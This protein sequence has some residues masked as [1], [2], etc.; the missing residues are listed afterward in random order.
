MERV[1]GLQ[2]PENPP[3]TKNPFSVRF[4]GGAHGGRVIGDF[5]LRAA[6][7]S[8]RTVP[9]LTVQDRRRCLRATD[10]RA[11]LQNYKEQTNTLVHA[12]LSLNF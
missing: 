6:N 2:I 1:I 3:L 11:T 10:D 12:E 8:T 9:H 7:R 5:H 4:R